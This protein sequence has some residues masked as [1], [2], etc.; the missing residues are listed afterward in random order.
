MVRLG[1]GEASFRRLV[2]RCRRC[3][4]GGEHVTAHACIADLVVQF[5]EQLV[6]FGRVEVFT[7][8]A[9]VHHLGFGALFDPPFLFVG[10][11]VGLDDRLV[12]EVPALATLRCA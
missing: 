4:R 1:S 6:H 10:G 7:V 12:V 2:D 3:G 11:F 5:G 9:V 8:A